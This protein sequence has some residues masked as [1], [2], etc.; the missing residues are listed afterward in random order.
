MAD[1]KT[2][3]PVLYRYVGSDTFPGIPA[4]D[5]SQEDFDRLP[6]LRQLDVKA[7]GSYELVEST[8]APK[9]P[10]NKEGN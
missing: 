2:D 4:N 1:Q 6:I 9:K 5:L 7:N 8:K 10:E 3:K